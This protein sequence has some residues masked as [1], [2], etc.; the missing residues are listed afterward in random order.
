MMLVER[1][2]LKAASAFCILI[3]P[4]IA[5]A[6]NTEAEMWFGLVGALVLGLITFFTLQNNEKRLADPNDKSMV[7]LDDLY[8]V[9]ELKPA[10]KFLLHIY[11]QSGNPQQPDR[12][13]EAEDGITEVPPSEAIKTVLSTFR[14]AKIDHVYIVENSSGTLQFQRPL[15]HHGG[16]KEGKKVRGAVIKAITE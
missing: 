8:E 3:F 5:H 1:R 14:R 12:V 15:H 11:R 13:V 6:K 10:R 4:S 7:M 16:A 2:L 9:S